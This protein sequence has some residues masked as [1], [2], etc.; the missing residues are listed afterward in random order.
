M[1]W[2]LSSRYTQMST[3]CKQFCE[4]RTWN[5]VSARWPSLT[6][7]FKLKDKQEAGS[8]STSFSSC[9][10]DSKP[11]QTET[12]G[13]LEVCVFLCFI[14]QMCLNASGRTSSKS[15]LQPITVRIIFSRL[16]VF[17]TDTISDPSA[18]S[19]CMLLYP[20]LT[21][22]TMSKARLHQRCL[23]QSFRIPSISKQFYDITI[24]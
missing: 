5:R 3:R 14:K 8:R 17:I 15:I 12:K 6:L 2:V 16:R 4:Q 7:Q 10:S 13:M 20:Y 24:I 22:L 11:I 21:N 18:P 1:C 19:A 9:F 23:I